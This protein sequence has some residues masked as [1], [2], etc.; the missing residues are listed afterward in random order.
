M[1]N[2][3]GVSANNDQSANYSKCPFHGG[4]CNH[5]KCIVAVI[6]KNK[7]VKCELIESFVTNNNVMI[8][9]LKQVENATNELSTAFQNLLEV[10][11]TSKNEIIHKLDMM[12]K[13]Q[14]RKF[15]KL[16]TKFLQQNVLQEHIHNYHLHPLSHYV[17]EYNVT[18]EDKKPIWGSRFVPNIQPALFLLQEWSCCVDTDNDG[19][20]YGK[21]FKI[22]NKDH[23]KPMI[24]KN[25]EL[26]PHWKSPTGPDSKISYQEYLTQKVKWGGDE[27]E[28]DLYKLQENDEEDIEDRPTL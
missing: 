25:I 6:E 12:H 16:L 23:S 26:S 19:K 21:D 20:I 10:L 11:N 28:P 9:S 13:T 14:I 15:N 22:S 7:F 5:K 8:D 18:D 2:Y 27:N 1:P 24:L 3:S 17:A 4:A